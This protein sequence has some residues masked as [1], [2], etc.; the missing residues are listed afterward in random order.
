MSLVF[1]E[2]WVVVLLR[3]EVV[4]SVWGGKKGGWV[5]FC[6]RDGLGPLCVWG[7]IVMICTSEVSF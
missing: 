3:S 6:G 7:A 2:E 4:E 1:G 5:M